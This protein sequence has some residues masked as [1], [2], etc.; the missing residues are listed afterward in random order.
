MNDDICFAGTGAEL[1]SIEKRLRRIQ[2]MGGTVAIYEQCRLIYCA[3]K[4]AERRAAREKTKK[5]N[6]NKRP[7]TSE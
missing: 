1:A 5:R 4:K 3:L 6:E 7:N 2:L